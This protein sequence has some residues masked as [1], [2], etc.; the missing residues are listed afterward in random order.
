MLSEIQTTNGKYEGLFPNASL[1]INALSE[2]L[3]DEEIIVKK[4]CLDFMIN[5]LDLTDN[6]FTEELLVTLC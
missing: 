6:I 2:C 4:N 5:H 1:V 3:K